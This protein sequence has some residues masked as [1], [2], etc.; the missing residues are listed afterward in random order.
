LNKR[1]YESF[2]SNNQPKQTNNSFESTSK[3]QNE[4]NNMEK[5]LIDNEKTEF[6]GYEE[7]IRS[8]GEVRDG[9][10]T[11]NAAAVVPEE[12]IGDV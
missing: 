7:Y 11:V 3:P 5:T 1:S 4:S 6:R 12:V 8:Q 10:S 9:D 2:M